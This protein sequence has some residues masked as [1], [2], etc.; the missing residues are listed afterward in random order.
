M[1]VNLIM[2]VIVIGRVIVNL[3]R[4]V[5]VNLRVNLRVSV[6]MS[7]LMYLKV[8]SVMNLIRNEIVN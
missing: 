5:R 7:E 8:N 4:I 3:I 2:I 1:R 6:I